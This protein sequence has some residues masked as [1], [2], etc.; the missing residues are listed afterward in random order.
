MTF[1]K[2]IISLYGIPLVKPHI[3]RRGIDIH[4][5]EDSVSYGCRFDQKYR[6]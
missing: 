5:L 2:K 6:D 4:G 1:T 3:N